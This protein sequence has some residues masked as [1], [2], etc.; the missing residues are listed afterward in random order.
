[1]NDYTTLS[2]GK[3]SLYKVTSKG[4]PGEINPIL[5][6]KLSD[7][8]IN[9]NKAEKRFWGI[10]ILIVISQVQK[11]EM[12]IRIMPSHF[13]DILNRLFVRVIC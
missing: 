5:G 13:N 11:P 4:K 8:G 10:L 6:S 9:L 2:Q 1:M 7:W 3:G 12:F